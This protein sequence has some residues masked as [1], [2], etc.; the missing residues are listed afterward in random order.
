MKKV[1]VINYQG[2]KE[3]FSVKKV[4][5]SARRVGASRRLAEEIAN[6]IATEVYEGITTKEIFSKVRS[7]LKK[8]HPSASL[9]FSLKKGIK[10]LGPTG[11]PFEKYI[12]EIFKIQGY[13]VK[14][15]QYIKG[16]CLEYEIDF[17]AQKEDTL[18][19]GECKYR[20]Q[21]D[22]LVRSDYALINYARFLDIQKGNFYRKQEEKGLKIKSILVTNTKFT[23]RAIKYSQWAGVELLGWKYPVKHGLEYLIDSQ[24][25]YPITILPS[26]SKRLTNILVSKKIMLA[27]DILN[28]NKEE[29]RGINL[30]R[31]T[32]EA[33]SLVS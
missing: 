12:G 25:L 18:Y 20:N 2:Q 27:K 17:I 10:K 13:E 8:E 31:V 23:Q 5:L 1:H 15:N 3:P 4:Y 30:D 19:I 32:K 22:G 9:R 21:S 6:I 24:K 33:Q 16:D 26:L 14:M 11:F 28:L 29:F 7:L